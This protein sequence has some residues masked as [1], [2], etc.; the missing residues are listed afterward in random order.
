[1][2]VVIAGGHGKVALALTRLLVE[3]GDRVRG[4][5][6]KPEQEQDLREAGSEP[7]V[8]DLE[9]LDD[10]AVA[11]A[12]GTPD[13]LVYAAG[14]GP[15]SGPERKR[16]MDLG[17][18]LKTIAA[19]RENG[20]ARYV[21]VSSMGAGA[22]PPGDEGM[23]PY[24]HAK[25]QADGT[26]VESGLEYTIVRPGSLTDDPP[27]GRVKVGVDVG[28]GRIPRADV[29]AVLVAVLDQPSSTGRILEV[30]SGEEP[31]A[32]AVRRFSR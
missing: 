12:V 24:L 5:I 22:P 13:A 17:G 26:L 1:M 28:R 9:Q 7:V 25:A 16:T 21:M 19:A 4:L 18:A 14:A 20:I 32:E 23:A 15:G 29:A 8:C 10:Q 6:R 3:R 31:V 2:D 30:I 27:T 11:E